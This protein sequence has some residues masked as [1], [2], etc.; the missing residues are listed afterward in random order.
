MNESCPP[1]RLKATIGS[2]T[3]RVSKTFLWISHEQM[4]SQ[5][6]CEPF[7]LYML[8]IGYTCNTLLYMIE[9]RYFG[10]K[11]EQMT[12][13]D[14]LW[15]PSLIFKDDR[16]FDHFEGALSK[17]VH[18]LS[19]RIMHE[20][21]TYKRENG[22]NLIRYAP[23]PFKGGRRLQGELSWW[24]WRGSFLRLGNLFRRADYHGELSRHY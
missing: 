6:N 13:S 2:N 5:V 9:T 18:C 20:M 3:C 17:M 21:K 11:L 22:V 1:F 10:G 8:T 15:P 16:I 24:T 4:F 7:C 19:D 14:V 23:G 12:V